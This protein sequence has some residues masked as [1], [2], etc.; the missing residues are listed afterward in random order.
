MR[1]ASKVNGLRP[2]KTQI[3]R[4]DVAD[5]LRNAIAG[6][7]LKPGQ[8]VLEVELAEELGVSRLPIREAIRQLEHEGL[9]VSLPHRGTFVAQVTQDDI[10]EMFS[11]REALESLA[12]RLVA[13]RASPAEVAALQQLVDEM[14]PAS[15]RRDYATLFKIDTEFH[16]LLCTYARHERL[17]KHW[18][19]VYGQWQALD[20]LMDEIPT[21]DA[22]P[23]DHPVIVTLSHFAD[24][25]Q[26]LVDAVRTGSPDEAERSMHRHMAEAQQSTLDIHAVGRR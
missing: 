18:N 16:T 14:G 2:L 19:L 5:A 10:R 8:R 11:L 1:S 22:L 25:H 21:L 23:D 20:S 17:L 9:L 13:E 3:L 24:M 6:G 12:A 26:A 4:H 15:A 7:V